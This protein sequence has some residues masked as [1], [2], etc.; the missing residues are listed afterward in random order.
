MKAGVKRKSMYRIDQEATD[1]SEG[2]WEANN[3]KLPLMVV[4][5]YVWFPIYHA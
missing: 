1:E 2:V 4:S 5:G 3:E